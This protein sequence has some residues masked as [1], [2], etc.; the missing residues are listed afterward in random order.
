MNVLIYIHTLWRMGPG[1]GGGLWGGGR[2][3]QK[4]N[5]HRQMFEETEKGKHRRKK[6]S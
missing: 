2:D 5:Q 3:R 6:E 4:E 1:E